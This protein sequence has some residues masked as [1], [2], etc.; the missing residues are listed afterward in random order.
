MKISVII[1]TKNEEKNISECLK[2]LSFFDEIIIVDDFSTDGTI[3]IVDGLHDKRIKIFQRNLDND[4]STQRNFA[5]SKSKNKYVLFLDADERIDKNLE[6]EIIL[7]DEKFD[8]Y[9][10]KRNDSIWGRTLKYGEAGNLYLVR[11][12]DKEKGEWVGKVHER[13]EIKGSIR[14]LRNPLAHYP[15]QSV[16]E[17]LKE[18]NYYTSLRSQE[19]YDAKI[20]SGF[21]QL[22]LYT[23]AKFFV[24]YIMKQG[25]RDGIQGFLIAI[26]M[27]FHSFLVRGKL[28]L[29]WQKN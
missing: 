5:L 10:F 13:W 25:F 22:I 4:F 24:N 26:L 27:S 8:G 15:H 21:I 23:K 9:S 18:I 29:L 19:L 12:A 6:D 20:K 11:L 2:C 14:R 3:A 7:L 16:S 17:F 1:L 28:W